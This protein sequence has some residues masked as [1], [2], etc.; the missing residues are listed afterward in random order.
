MMKIYQKNKT[1][2][3]KAR[4]VFIAYVKFP[5]DIDEI[6]YIKIEHPVDIGSY[7]WILRVQGATWSVTVHQVGQD[8]PAEKEANFQQ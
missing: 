1:E 7:E 3:K 2:K 5:H 8:C 4:K 6:S